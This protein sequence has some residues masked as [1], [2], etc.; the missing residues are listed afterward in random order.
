MC[1][2]V[3]SC[4]WTGGVLP[5]MFCSWLEAMCLS[6][7]W[8]CA[9]WCACKCVHAARAGGGL[10]FGNNIDLLLHDSVL[11][12]M[13]DWCWLCLLADASHVRLKCWEAYCID[14]DILSILFNRCMPK[15][16]AF[17]NCRYRAYVAACAAALQQLAMLLPQQQPG[18]FPANAAVPP[19]AVGCMTAEE[20]TALGV[21]IPPAPFR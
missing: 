16:F 1:L 13:F 19:A 14:P 3:R 9:W 10:R 21:A 17:C 7:A 5:G 12:S 6:L 2:S 8:H 18:R 20:A 4:C 11:A 15:H